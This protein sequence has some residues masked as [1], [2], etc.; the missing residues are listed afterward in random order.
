MADLDA[1][2]LVGTLKSSPETSNMVTLSQYLAGHLED[3]RRA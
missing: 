2:F 1:L 3:Q